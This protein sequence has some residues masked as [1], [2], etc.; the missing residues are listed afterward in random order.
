MAHHPLCYST[1]SGQPSLNQARDSPHTSSVEVLFLYT[2][3]AVTG[4]AA[5][6]ACQA[7]MA[8]KDMRRENGASERERERRVSKTRFRRTRSIAIST[9][10]I[11]HGRGRGRTFWSAF[12]PI[13]G[14]VQNL[15][16]C[17]SKGKGNNF[18][19]FM[20]FSVIL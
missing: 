3:S 15:S 5:S 6:V 7:G 18:S 14:G 19:D 8:P 11:L 9:R 1:F 10:N 13:H 17:F 20:T 2:R 12:H 4:S 16:Y